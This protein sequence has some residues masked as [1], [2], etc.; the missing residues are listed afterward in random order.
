MVHSTIASALSKLRA[1]LTEMVEA[2]PASEGIGSSFGLRGADVRHGSAMDLREFLRHSMDP[3]DSE[4]SVF[5]KL[6]S[7]GVGK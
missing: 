5:Q 4:L 6:L 1:N 3:V 7:F 2:G